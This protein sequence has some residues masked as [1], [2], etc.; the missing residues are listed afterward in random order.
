MDDIAV[1]KLPANAASNESRVVEFFGMYRVTFRCR[2]GQAGGQGMGS[3]TK[4]TEKDPTAKFPHSGVM[5]ETNRMLG[6][7]TESERI[8]NARHDEPK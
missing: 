1:G 6:H 7:P 2:G 8:K 5:E 3:S 4:R